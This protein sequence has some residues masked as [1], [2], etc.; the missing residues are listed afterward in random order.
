VREGLRIMA[1]LFW[2]LGQP[3]ELER[4]DFERRSAQ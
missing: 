1:G 4:P 3:G 2:D